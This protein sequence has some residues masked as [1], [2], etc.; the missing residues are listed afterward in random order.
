MWWRALLRR[1]PPSFRLEQP[2][3]EGEVLGFGHGGVEVGEDLAGGG[4]VVIE[5]VDRGHREELGGGQVG[6]LGFADAE[7]GAVRL[8]GGGRDIGVD[9]RLHVGDV[10]HVGRAGAVAA[11]VELAGAEERL[12]VAAEQGP[13]GAVVPLRQIAGDRVDLDFGAH[14]HRAGPE[15]AVDLQVGVDDRLQG[16]AAHKGFHRHLGRHNADRVAALGDDRVDADRV[17]VVKGLALAVDRVE[18]DHRGGERVDAELRRAAGV[19]GAPEKTDLLD[20]RAVRRIR[21]ERALRHLVVRAGMDHHRNHTLVLYLLARNRRIE[22]RPKRILSKDA[23][24]ESGFGRSIALSR[25]FRESAEI[26]QIRGFHL[27]FGGSLLGRRAGRGSSP[28][29]S[30]LPSDGATTYG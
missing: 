18:R 7:I 6:V 5:E 2:S 4:G 3:G 21:N 15:A 22:S 17:L 9:D 14:R 23:N 19:A 13:E 11:D 28:R 8:A 27:V 20:Q 29:L 25:P 16:A 10:A 1:S 12:D 24:Y 30:L 26:V